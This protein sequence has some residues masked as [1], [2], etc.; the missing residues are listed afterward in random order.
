MLKQVVVNYFSRVQ[1]KWLKNTERPTTEFP[2]SD[3]SF[4]TDIFRNLN[5]NADHQAGNVGH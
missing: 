4:Q 1:H 2:K 3:T 5:E